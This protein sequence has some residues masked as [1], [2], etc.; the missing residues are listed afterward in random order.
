MI[1]PAFDLLSDSNGSGFVFNVGAAD[2]TNG[3]ECSSCEIGNDSL[4]PI[5]EEDNETPEGLE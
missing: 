4:L 5:G 3:I 1:V 2:L